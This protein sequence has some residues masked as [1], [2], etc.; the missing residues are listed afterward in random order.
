MNDT[1]VGTGETAPHIHVID[2]RFTRFVA[3]IRTSAIEG[4]L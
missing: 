4:A 1:T 3:L 2:L